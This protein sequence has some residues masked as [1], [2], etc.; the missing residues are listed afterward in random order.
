MKCIS[1]MRV[2]PFEWVRRTLTSSSLSLQIEQRA[3]VIQFHETSFIV[4]WYGRSG[5][6][7]YL[8][9]RKTAVK[10][11]NEFHLFAGNGSWTV[12]FPRWDRWR[13]DLLGCSR[14]LLSDEDL[15]KYRKE[16]VSFPETY[17]VGRGHI[18][19]IYL[20]R[21]PFFYFPVNYL[22]TTS[23]F[24]MKKMMKTPCIH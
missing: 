12:R 24:E 21:L 11:P 18:M 13:W 22:Y 1:F 23:D 2:S 15:D 9:E 3:R 17:H 6:L 16:T 14:H 5:S 7:K 19:Q 20:I 4:H 8:V 10:F